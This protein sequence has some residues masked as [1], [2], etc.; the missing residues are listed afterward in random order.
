MDFATVAKTIIE[1]IEDL[2]I[3]YFVGGSVAAC[4]W[5]IPRATLD[6]DI[7]VAMTPRQTVLLASALGEDWYL[8]V[9]MARSALEHDRAFNVIHK[10]SSY[11]FDLF[12]AYTDFHASE[13]KRAT[14]EPLRFPGGEVLCFVASAEDSILAK[15]QWYR[16][17][18]EV[19]ERQWSDISGVFV[20]TRN[21]DAGYLA[22]WAKR[23]GVSDLLERAIKMTSEPT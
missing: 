17:G 6:T 13:L 9:D 5:G 11:R 3:A 21:L 8:D 14:R 4:A 1:A 10:L 7:V 15:L 16:D 18:G 19:S 23:L 22:K 12:P 2:D 20:I